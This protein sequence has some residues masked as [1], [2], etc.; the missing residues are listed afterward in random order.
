MIIFEHKYKWLFSFL[1][2]T[3]GLLPHSNLLAEDIGITE[4][5]DK[6]HIIVCM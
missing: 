3:W 2:I 4:I 5:N 1:I 6:H